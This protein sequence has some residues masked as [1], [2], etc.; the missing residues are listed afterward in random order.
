MAKACELNITSTSASTLQD[1]SNMFE[2]TAIT[3]KAQT[4]LIIRDAD[5]RMTKTG[6]VINLGILHPVAPSPY[7]PKALF[8]PRFAHLNSKLI[9]SPCPLVTERPKP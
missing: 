4:M 1:L 5:V 9:P 6:I 7:A 2:R 3:S 8:P